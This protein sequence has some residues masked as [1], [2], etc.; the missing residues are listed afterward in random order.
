MKRLGKKV[1]EEM[2]GRVRAEFPWLATFA[3]EHPD[4]S[5]SDAVVRFNLACMHHGITEFLGSG[6][7][8]DALS[9][10]ALLTGTEPPVKPRKPPPDP[11][12]LSMFGAKL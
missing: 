6:P 10:W 4:P 1:R 7:Y 9:G 3:V 5:D 11:N 8:S 2:A 12:Q